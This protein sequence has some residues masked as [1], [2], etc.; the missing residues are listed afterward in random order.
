MIRYEEEKELSPKEKKKLL[1]QKAKEAAAAATVENEEGEDPMEAKKKAL[2]EKLKAKKEAVSEP[3]EAKEPEPPKTDEAIQSEAPVEEPPA[4]PVGDDKAGEAAATPKEYSFPELTRDA[5]RH[6]AGLNDPNLPEWM[7][8][9]HA[10]ADEKVFREDFASDE[11]FEAAVLPVPPLNIDGETPAP[12][13]LQELADEMVHL[14]LLEMNELINKI[15]DHYGFNEGMLS[16]D[17]VDDGEDDEPAE[18][19]APVEEKTIFDIKLVGYDDKAKIKVIKEVRAI[20]G[21]GLK[22]AKELV[23]GAP[24]T[25]LKDIKKEQAEEIKSKLEEIGATV[26]VV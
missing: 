3:E 14:S 18:E 22:E 19:A 24:K 21:L 6:K 4:S 15:A 13:H 5:A 23:E 20:T 10:D 9:L 8:P 26:E 25:L 2:Q 1:K 12:P 7:N 16:P 11:E 17:E